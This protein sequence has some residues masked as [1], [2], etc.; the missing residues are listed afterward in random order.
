[1]HFK[2][3][4][5]ITFFLCLFF[6]F[7]FS[8]IALFINSRNVVQLDQMMINFIQG[9][10]SPILTSIMKFFTYIGSFK[11]VAAFALLF[12]FLLYRLT[13]NHAELTLFVTVVVGTPLIN[14]VLKNYFHRDRPA[15]HQLIEIGGYS[16]PSGH[17]MNAFVVYGIISFLLW[18]YIPNIVGRSTLIL[19]S[20]IFIIMIGT[21]RIYLGVHYPSDI[22]GGY[23]AGGVWLA[24]SIGIFQRHHKKKRNRNNIIQE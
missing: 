19:C 23:S 15:I 2:N 8:W 14:A 13:K 24:L 9:F 4:L 12:S 6:L 22:I 21:S 16:F 3:N 7:V 11:I 1:M 18:R 5:W 10:E 17:A 20:T